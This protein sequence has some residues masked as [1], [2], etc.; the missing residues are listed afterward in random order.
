M[1]LIKE[2]H[3]GYVRDSYNSIPKRYI[4]QFEMEKK[5]LNKHFPKG[6]VPVAR[7]QSTKWARHSMLTIIAFT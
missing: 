2:S 4:C 7:I 5:Q 6:T 1:Y 3:G